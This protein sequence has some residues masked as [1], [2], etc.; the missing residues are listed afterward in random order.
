MY[1]ED[2]TQ[3]NIFKINYIYTIY[4]ENYPFWTEYFSPKIPSIFNKNNT[5]NKQIR[6]NLN[7]KT[8]VTNTI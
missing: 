7:I 8:N 4:K 1:L 6:I 5:C 3:T 2:Y